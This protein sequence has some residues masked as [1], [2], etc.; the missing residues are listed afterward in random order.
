[1]QISSI[2]DRIARRAPNPKPSSGP[3]PP[4]LSGGLPVIGHTLEFVRSTIDL[5]FRAQRELGEVAG[6]RVANKNMVAL[7]GQE[8]HEAVFRA[9]DSQLNP[10]EAYKIMTPVFGKNMVYDAPPDR[11]SVV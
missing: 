6:L 8:A 9:P 4:Q 10:A 11:Q 3:K 2:T 5:L 1:M 7:F